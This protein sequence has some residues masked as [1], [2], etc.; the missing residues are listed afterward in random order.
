M[1]QIQRAPSELIDARRATPHLE[2]PPYLEFEAA[3]PSVSATHYLLLLYRHKWSIVGFITACLLATFLI[4][5]RLTP[6]YEATAKID[7]DRRIPMGVVGQE[8]SQGMTGDDADAFMATQGELIQS[9]AVLRPVAERFNLLQKEKQ[10]AKL[11]AERARKKSDAPVYLNNLKITRPVNTYILNIS[12]RSPDPQL[13]ANVANAIARSYLEHTF[14]IR[15]QSSNALSAFME[16]Q[17]DELRVKVENSDLALAKFERDLNVINPEDKTNILSSRLLQLN[18]E[19]TNAQGDRVRKEA[20]FKSLQSG[21]VAAA[22]VS[23]QGDE[24]NRLQDRVNQAKQHLASVA[25]IYGPAHQEYRKASNDLTEVQRQ[26]EEMRRSVAQRVET[27][28]RQALTREEMLSKAVTQTK[29]EYDQLNA[30]SFKYQQLK[31]DADTN[32]ALYS[33]LE[34]RIKEAGINAGFQNS[35]I[36]IA[37]LARPPDAPIFPR[38]TLYMILVFLVSSV[39]AA[40]T[41]VLV[42]LLDNTIRDPEQA[43]HALDTSVL[44][45]LPTVKEKRRLLNPLTHTLAVEQA[46]GIGREEN[47]RPTFGVARLAEVGGPLRRRDSKR[48]QGLYP[49]SGKYGGI[50]SYEEAIRTLRHSILLPDF[51]RTVRSLLLTSAAPGEGKSTAIIHLAIAHA[52]QGKRTLIIDADLRR[53]SIH[54]KL[55]LN[56]G[57]GLSNALLGEINWKEGAIPAE[58][59]ADVRVLPAGTASRRASDLIGSAMIDIL[60]EAGKE[61]DLILVDAPPLLG[62][63]ETMQIATAVD[64]VVVMARAGQTSRR[65]VAS[66]LATLKR[67]RANTIGLVLNEVDKNSTHGYYYYGEYRK[68]YARSAEQNG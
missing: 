67:L 26:F 35:S 1:K 57:P 63:A 44:G 43:A 56:L 30:E 22:E 37:D 11:P 17:L 39:I 62:F 40:C 53:P 47:G 33:D 29:A 9:D 55:E 54:K 16:K 31:R 46:S 66:V 13:A 24:L 32:K 51:D 5:S 6:I 60:D 34:R 48:K 36:R 38:K 41:A 10:L 19:F 68:Y 25:S 18:T 64:G 42:D 49:S 61:Y 23:G 12:Y 65:A 14:D 21:T 50:S 27:D 2:P 20:A 59:W 8:A 52:E 15:I 4:A 3:R 45:T 7:V 58:H 28:Y